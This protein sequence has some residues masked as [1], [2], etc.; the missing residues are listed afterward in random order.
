MYHNLNFQTLKI[1]SFFKKSFLLEKIS[2]SKE[3]CELK[4]L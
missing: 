1:K 3:I 2:V 4:H